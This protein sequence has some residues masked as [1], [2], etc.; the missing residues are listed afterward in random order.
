M[1]ESNLTQEISIFKD[2]S[3]KP[4]WYFI[5][6]VAVVV[7]IVVSVKTGV[8]KTDSYKYNECLISCDENNSCLKSVIN[9]REEPSRMEGPAICVEY[10]AP[11]CKNICVERYK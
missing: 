6:F 7:L 2:P 9:N 1:E 4:I 5:S 10:S 8:I 3:N 11:A